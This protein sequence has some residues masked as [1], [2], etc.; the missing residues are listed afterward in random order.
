MV[1]TSLDMNWQTLM[2]TLVGAL[3]TFSAILFTQALEIRKQRR[4]HAKLVDALLQGLHDE[5][6]GLLELARTGAARPIEAITEG[7]TYEGLFTASQDYFTVYHANAAWVMQIDDASLRR[8]VIQTYM[9]AK[10]LLDTVCMN[11]L[12]LERYHYLQSTFLKTKDASVQKEAEEYH[13]T[14]VYTA[15]Q[16]KR[17]DAAFK[18]AGSDLLSRLTAGREKWKAH[19][20]VCITNGHAIAAGQS[21]LSA[22]MPSA[23]HHPEPFEHVPTCLLSTHLKQ[24]SPAI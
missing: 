20:A 17:V 6:T 19:E 5:V 16:L 23:A 12:Y 7:K 13:L 10:V 18:S 9:R 21:D 4:A 8:E 2:S 14:L 11:R 1:L 22:H 24:K 3:L 15:A